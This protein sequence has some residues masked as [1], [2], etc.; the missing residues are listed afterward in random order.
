MGCAIN[1]AVMKVLARL[2]VRSFVPTIVGVVHRA[3][4]HSSLFHILR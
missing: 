2:S 4:K 1:L 3:D